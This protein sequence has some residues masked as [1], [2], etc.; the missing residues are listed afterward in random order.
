MHALR[1][2][3]V[4]ALLSFPTVSLATITPL[5]GASA[6]VTR[7]GA[8]FPN[9]VGVLVLDHRGAPV[10]NLD[11][12]I[13]TP[14]NAPR[15]IGGMYFDLL[16]WHSQAKTDAAGKAVMHT[17]YGFQAG[18]ATL[19]FSAWPYGE[20]HIDLRVENSGPPA[21]LVIL[22]G[23]GQTAREG[24]E[25]E[26]PFRVQV[27]DDAGIPVRHA[28]VD[29]T[30]FVPGGVPYPFPS[31]AVAAVRGT[32]DGLP[33]AR[34]T[35][36]EQGVATSPRFTVAMANVNLAPFNS[37]PSGKQAGH[38]FVLVQALSDAGSP[39]ADTYIGYDVDLASGSRPTP[40]DMWWG[41]PE[42]NGWG[43]SIVEHG[44]G[45]PGIEPDLFT[46]LFIYDAQGKPTWYV[47]PAGSWENP[48]Y[49]TTWRGYL[50]KPKGSPFFAYDAGALQVG[51]V[52]GELSIRFIGK[53]QIQLDYVLRDAPGSRGGGTKRLVR[54]DFTGE[55]P[56]P[57][58]GLGDMWWGGLAQNGWGLSLLEQTGN[59]FGVW[60]TYDEAGA[61]TWF[62]MPGGSWT[63]PTTY[64]GDL[65]R[66]RGAR[67]AGVP[68]DASALRVEP[69]GRLRIDAASSSTLRANYEADGHR[70]T[71]LLQRQPFAWHE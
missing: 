63:N 51:N 61:P 28:L 35:A 1:I 15:V 17:A 4:L 71:L 12:Y 41:G 13:T 47:M 29:F 50:Y 57:R 49:G 42:E 22:S 7:V 67:W 44:R 46:V 36:D 70:G 43:L 20:A 48:G 58:Q 31:S 6:Q 68:Y 23:A 62:V 60:L 59:L 2:F 40:Q 56:S 33:F 52:E 37:A 16:R 34:V 9:P 25:L 18:T 26:A 21:S 55:A 14:L 38:G 45:L 54:Q 64:E 19:I 24:A 66:T 69:V 8:A 27:L 10:P 32:F 30:S 39:R 65:Y 53:D 5:P 3:A 11:V